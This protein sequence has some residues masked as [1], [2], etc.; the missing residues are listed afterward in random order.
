MNSLFHVLQ[1]QYTRQEQNLGKKIWK[2]EVMFGSERNP[3]MPVGTLHGVPVVWTIVFHRVGYRHAQTRSRGSDEE[4]QAPL[5]AHSAVLVPTTARLVCECGGLSQ[6]L[7]LLFV[8][9]IL[10]LEFMYM[11]VF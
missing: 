4:P 11:S 9:S 8:L 10:V 1:L 7:C 3:G 6:I 5:L 2:D